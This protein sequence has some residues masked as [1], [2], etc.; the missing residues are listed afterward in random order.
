[1]NMKKNIK[2]ILAGVCIL[3][4]IAS[5][6]LPEMRIKAASVQELGQLM[7]TYREKDGTFEFTTASRFYIVSDLEPSEELI[8][9]VQLAS[10]QF[11]ADAKPSAAI[12]D[13]VWGPES[14][15]KTGDIIV[16]LDPS[17][18]IPEEGYALDVADQ[19]EVIASDVDGLLYGLNMLHKCIRG[20]GNNLSGFFASDVPDTKERTVMLDCARKYYTKDWICNFIRQMSWMGYNTIQL[21]FSEDGGF[22]ADFWDPEYYKGSFN[23]TNDLTWLCGSHVQSWVHDGYDVDSHQRV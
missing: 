14:W 15:S 18:G 6:M 13:I 8:Q 5:Y 23:P 10:Q 4:L 1:M 7:D 3:G 12:L 16:K 2:R 20:Y 22:R 17:S 9:T 11:A 19:A 21:H